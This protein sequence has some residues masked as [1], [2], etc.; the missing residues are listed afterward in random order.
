[1]EKPAMASKSDILF[2]TF[3][4]LLGRHGGRLSPKDLVDEARPDSSPLHS[5]FEWDN[6][7]A[8]DRYR[9]VQAGYLIR[10]WRGQIIKIESET[11]TI[12][13]ETQRVLQ[14]PASQRSD[15][16]S[17]YIATSAIMADASL[18][19]DMLQTVLT[20]LKAYRQRYA[21]LSEL[22]AVW[23]V[24]DDALGGN[25]AERIGG[26]PVVVA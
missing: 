3:E 17:S 8:S 12:V 18:R 1:M 2:A 15:G 16:G 14:S 7:I 10:Q 23:S 11:K 25:S 21:S 24:I 22:A 26:N 13:F 9:L 19:S 5:H 6:E 20:E 4:A